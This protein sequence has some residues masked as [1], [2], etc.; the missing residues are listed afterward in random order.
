MLKSG[1]KVGSRFHVVS[2]SVIKIILMYIMSLAKPWLLAI[3][4]YD[5]EEWLVYR[6]VRKE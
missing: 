2:V 3:R 6:S 1:N 5:L 4:C